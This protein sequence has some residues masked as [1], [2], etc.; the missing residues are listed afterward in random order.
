MSPADFEMMEA[1]EHSE[2]TPIQANLDN[3]PTDSDN[4]E[5]DFAL[6]DDEEDD[7]LAFEF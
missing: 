2:G 3:L 6:D 1:I 7:G 5:V 4:F